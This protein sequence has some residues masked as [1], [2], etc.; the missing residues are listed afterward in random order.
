[1]LQADALVGQASHHG[2]TVTGN[3]VVVVV[4][5]GRDVVP[6]SI[7]DTALSLSL[8]SLLCSLVDATVLTVDVECNSIGSEG[9]CR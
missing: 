4:I 9:G 6:S 2:S 1:M 3:G 7:S 5:V 8:L